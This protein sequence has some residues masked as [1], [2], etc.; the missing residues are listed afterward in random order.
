M[1]PPPMTQEPQLQPADPSGMSLAGRMMNMFASP[2]EAF[3]EVKVSAP[4]TANWL[5]PAV[6][7]ILVAWIGNY[8]VFSQ[9][10]IKHQITEMSAKAMEKQLAKMPKEQAD[11]VREASEKYGDIGAKVSAAVLP[12][13]LGLGLPFFWGAILWLVGTKVFQG[14]FTYMKAVEVTGLGNTIGILEAILRTLLILVMGSLFAAPNLALLVK[15]FDPQNTVHGLLALV[16][17][18]TLWIL[19]V[20]SI[21]LARLSGV[22]F[23]KAACWV[24][25]IWAAYTGF[26]FA[27]GIAMRTLAAKGGAA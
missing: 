5:V 6:L 20:R 24:F 17:V 14:N 3:D 16:N 1:E 13:F 22:S 9:D 2:G 8:L 26:F 23:A 19:A 21:G 11:K 18:M 25:G 12:I 15:D 10:T 7:L 27:I 4:S